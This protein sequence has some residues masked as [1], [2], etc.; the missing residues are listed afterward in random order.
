MAEQSR[1]DCECGY[2]YY[3]SSVS[4]KCP[5][6]GKK[7]TTPAGYLAMIL[8]I[9]ALVIFLV[10]IAGSISWAYYSFKN[11]L[12]KWHSIGSIVLGLVSIFVLYNYFYDTEYPIMRTVAYLLNAIGVLLSLY[13]LSKSN[14][15]EN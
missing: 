14:E 3:T 5:D 1:I 8:I 2:S 11:K 4:S 7:N 10:L 13:H 12:S 6:C 15:N 9:A